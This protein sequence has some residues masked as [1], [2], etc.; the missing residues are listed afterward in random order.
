MFLAGITVHKTVHAYK[1][2]S[3]KSTGWLV[4]FSWTGSDGERR[5][6]ESVPPEADNRRNDPNRNWGLYE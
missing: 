5:Y 4:R 6:S 3:G 2:N 1:S